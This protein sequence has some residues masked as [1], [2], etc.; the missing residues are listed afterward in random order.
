[1]IE[2]EKGWVMTPTKPP[3]TNDRPGLYICCLRTAERYYERNER[4]HSPI[5]KGTI[6]VC[7]NKICG[8]RIE[9]IGGGWK[10]AD[11]N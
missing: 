9:Y 7:E 6:I 8:Q 5:P 1:M 3:A 2:A 4:L 11:A 10:N